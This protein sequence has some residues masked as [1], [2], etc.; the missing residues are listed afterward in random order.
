MLTQSLA[1]LSDFSRSSKSILKLQMKMDHA[2]LHNPKPIPGYPGTDKIFRLLPVPGTADPGSGISYNVDFKIL[3]RHTVTSL[4]QPPPD[5]IPNNRYTEKPSRT[6]LNFLFG[7]VR[8]L[9]EGRLTH[10]KVGSPE[11]FAGTNFFPNSF[12]RLPDCLTIYL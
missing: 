6:H 3:G 2:L 4:L 1:A 10:G 7:P 11:R 12:R 8:P 5:C 9:V